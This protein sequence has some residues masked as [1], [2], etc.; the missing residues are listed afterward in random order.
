MPLLVGVTGTEIALLAVIGLLLAA[1]VV[2]VI[3]APRLQ[4]ALRRRR[5]SDDPHLPERELLAVAKLGVEEGVIAA[6]ERKLIESILRFRDTVVREVM[7]PRPDMVT[8]DVSFRAGDAAEVMLF[9]GYSRMP[10][11]GEG[12]DDVVGL[13]YAKDLLRA[14]RDGEEN[15]PITQLMRPPR[16]VPETMRVPELLRDMQ[17]EQFHM[18]IVVDEYGGTAGLVTLEDLIEQLVGEIADEFD[19]Q[20]PLVERLPEGEL[21]VDARTSLDEVNE[22]LDAD[23]PDGDWDTIGG[24]LYGQLGRVPREGESIDIDGW[25]LVA[26]RIQGRRIG[27]VRISRISPPDDGSTAPART[28]DSSRDGG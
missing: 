28:P 22:L 19:V 20:L 16:F 6:D 24:L 23:L 12:I 9:N 21:L 17:R 7:V 26:Q 13:A 25:H 11:V 18:A 27:R 4:L 14:E 8:V 2:L 10:V 5:L 15:E 1:L 3:A